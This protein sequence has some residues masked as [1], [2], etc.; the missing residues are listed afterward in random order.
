MI[1]NNRLIVF[2]F[3]NGSWASQIQIG[4]NCL[5][6]YCSYN[7]IGAESVYHHMNR[8]APLNPTHSIES[9]L[10]MFK[11]K[12]LNYLLD[13]HFTRATR[14]ILPSHVTRQQY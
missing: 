12:R 1:N 9:R 11:C 7:G 3:E 13:R 8:F 14:F 5:S 6:E 10:L 2:I 4:R